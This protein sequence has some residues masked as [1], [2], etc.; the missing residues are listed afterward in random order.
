M[1]FD[2][3]SLLFP[4]PIFEYVLSNFVEYNN[5]PWGK[6]GYLLKNFYKEKLR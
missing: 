1:M 6:R 4:L 2:F 3:F 5:Y